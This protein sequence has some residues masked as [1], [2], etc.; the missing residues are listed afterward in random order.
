MT[1]QY[2]FS[3]NLG[4]PVAPLKPLVPQALYLI[5]AL[6]ANALCIVGEEFLNNITFHCLPVIFFNEMKYHK[7]VL[8][9]FEEPL[10]RKLNNPTKILRKSSY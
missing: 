6:Q 3:E 2:W 1:T 10:Y 8:D 7:H 5:K 9:L 4:R